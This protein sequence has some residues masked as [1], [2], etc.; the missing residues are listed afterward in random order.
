M[1]DN[2]RRWEIW[3]HPLFHPRGY[4][5][6]GGFHLIVY[7]YQLPATT[8]RW[9]P[10][11]DFQYP[12]HLTSAGPFVHHGHLRGYAH[13]GRKHSVYGASVRCTSRGNAIRYRAD[14]SEPPAASQLEPRSPFARRDITRTPREWS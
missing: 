14:N 4:S 5:Q 1:S 7:Y 10:S 9:L 11:K 13:T 12:Y 2:H 3:L 6:S 8:S